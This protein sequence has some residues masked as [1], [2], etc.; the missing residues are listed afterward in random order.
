MGNIQV[1][2]ATVEV[3]VLGRKCYLS[4]SDL[5]LWLYKSAGANSEYPQVEATMKFLAEQV[6][7]LEQK[8][9]KR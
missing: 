3:A 6:L 8:N 7:E 2:A 1:E 4:V 9:R 5:A